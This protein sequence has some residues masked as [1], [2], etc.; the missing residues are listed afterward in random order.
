M[1]NQHRSS[2]PP[3]PAPR[4]GVL[5]ALPIKTPAGNREKTNEER[6]KGKEAR[7]SNKL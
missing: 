2:L 3:M 4:C 6:V 7:S 1:D 5:Q